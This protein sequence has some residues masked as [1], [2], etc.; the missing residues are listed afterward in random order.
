MVVSDAGLMV[1]GAVGVLVVAGVMVVMAVVGVQAQMQAM[2]VL[3][4]GL[5]LH[6]VEHAGRRGAGEHDSQRHAERC[7]HGMQRR[8]VSS[9]GANAYGR[10]CWL[11]TAVAVGGSGAGRG[12]KPPSGP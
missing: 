10:R 5:V 12:L 4:L 2:L 3:D 7:D 9:H 6:P 8:P 1:A 11:A